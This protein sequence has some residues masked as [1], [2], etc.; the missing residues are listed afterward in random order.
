MVSLEFD[1][2]VQNGWNISEETFTNLRESEKDFLLFELADKKSS[3]Y[4]KKLPSKNIDYYKNRIEAIDFINNK[5]VLDA[6]CG[7]GQWSYCLSLLNDKVIA[8]DYNKDRVEI[9]KEL[10]KSRNNID[11]SHGNIESLK[12]INDE[13]VD[14]IFCYG[15][16]MFTNTSKT[17]KE[18]YRVLKP[19][20]KLY[21]NYNGYGVYIHQ[22]IK[23]FFTIDKS[24]FI[25]AYYMI[26]NSFV[27]NETSNIFTKKSIF[28]L[29]SK[30]DFLVENYNN[31]GCTN[32]K[33][34]ENIIPTYK[35]NYMFFPYVLELIATK[36]SK[37]EN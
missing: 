22:I 33:N 2:I 34:I 12:K 4:N 27:K 30:N 23:G 9:A 17:M 26:K 15:A 29:I 32:I 1:K 11:I 5:V 19:N 3:Y 14:S 20:G 28:E 21:L 35:S 8:L 36:K 10:N 24:L 25:N 31:E 13:S 16:F 7:I 18:F 6:A 37:N